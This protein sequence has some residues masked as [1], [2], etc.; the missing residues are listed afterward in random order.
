MLT[1]R[2]TTRLLSQLK[3]KP[4]P[5]PPASTTKLGDWYANLLHIGRTQL[6]LAVSEHTFLPV[7]VPASPVNSLVLRLRAGVVEVVR[8]VGVAEA[9][10]RVE[11][12]EMNDVAFAKTNNKVVVGV[13]VEFA[14]ALEWT[15]DSHPTPLDA[16]LYLAGMVSMA[17]RPDP[18]P[19]SATRKLFAAA[20]T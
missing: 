5:P 4:E 10:V 2:C 18:H 11:D 19:D 20:K 16:S 6:V 8:A 15:W 9:A 12:G 1:L 13:M 3:V 14:K 7:I 17:L